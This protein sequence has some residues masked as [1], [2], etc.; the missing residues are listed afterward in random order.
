MLTNKSISLTKQAN[1]QV[2][3]RVKS[4]DPLENTP[5]FHVKS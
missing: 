3:D 5:P 4:R 1:E 2:T